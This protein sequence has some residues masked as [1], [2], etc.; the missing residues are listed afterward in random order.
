MP[1]TTALFGTAIEAQVQQNAVVAT[2]AMLSACRP[3]RR[4]TFCHTLYLGTVAEL[5]HWTAICEHARISQQGFDVD[6]DVDSDSDHLTHPGALQIMLLL[7]TNTTCHRPFHWYVGITTHQTT[8]EGCQ[9]T[10][11]T[12]GQACS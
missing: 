7:A 1:A 12:S 11:T 6:S 8:V 9:S 4:C 5:L 3:T 2:S 10:V